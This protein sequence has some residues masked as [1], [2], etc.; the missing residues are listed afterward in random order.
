[1]FVFFIAHRIIALHSTTTLIFNSATTTATGFDSKMNTDKRVIAMESSATESRVSIFIRIGR[2]ID[3]DLWNGIV[4]ID[5]DTFKWLCLNWDFVFCLL[6]FF[7]C[8]CEK[9]VASYA[10]ICISKAVYTISWE[11]DEFC[12]TRMRWQKN[13]CEIWFVF[14]SRWACNVIS[15]LSYV[16]ISPYTFP[17]TYNPNTKKNIALK[18]ATQ[19]PIY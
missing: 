19:L 1:M 7:F 8:F 14:S 11:W 15:W 3:F 16:Y 5:I 4:H 12:G 2:C 13:R 6:C 18:H 17:A 10:V 9:A